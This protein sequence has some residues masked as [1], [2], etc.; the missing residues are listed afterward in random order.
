MRCQVKNIRI[1]RKFLVQKA[2][3]L[4]SHI[5]LIIRHGASYGR[6]TSLAL[7]ILVRR[8]QIAGLQ[9]WKRFLTMSALSE[10]HAALNGTA[11]RRGSLSL[12]NLRSGCFRKKPNGKN[13]NKS[14]GKEFGHK[15]WDRR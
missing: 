8:T 15:K 2:Q 1:T 6:E 14:C 7:E 9:E 4:Q 5:G 11:G 12:G 13:R 10:V 3:E